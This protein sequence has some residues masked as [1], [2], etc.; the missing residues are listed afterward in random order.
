[1]RTKLLLLFL[2]FG[3]ACAM[4]QNTLDGS[5]HA[6][7]IQTGYSYFDFKRGYHGLFLSTAYERDLYS[8]IS[9]QLNLALENGAQNL[10][11]GSAALNPFQSIGL[12]VGVN[13]KLNVLNGHTLG[14]GPFIGF[15][16]LG[17][18]ES[19]QNQ[20]GFETTSMSYVLM[21]YYGLRA[22]Y[23]FPVGKTVKL[24]FS[25]SLQRQSFGT[26][27]TSTQRFGFLF[28]KQF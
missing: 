13:G 1:M 4:A 6:L 21:L 2:A 12:D 22:S 9:A 18:G 19:F 8:F 3:I 28:I 10:D 23:T 11:S 17:A 5:G 27:K 7:K 20:N 16:F 24:G 14:G 26:A 25:G 15:M